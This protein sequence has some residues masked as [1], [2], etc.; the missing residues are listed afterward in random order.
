MPLRSKFSLGRYP[1]GR[2]EP[3][4]FRLASPLSSGK[5]A[6][7]IQGPH[8]TLQSNQKMDKKP[9]TLLLDCEEANP[10]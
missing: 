2:V 10:K 9:P 6:S 4:E 7:A 1:T 5:K 3:L 8:A